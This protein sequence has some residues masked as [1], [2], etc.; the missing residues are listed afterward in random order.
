VSNNYFCTVSFTHSDPNTLITI[1]LINKQSI[2]TQYNFHTFSTSI[3]LSNFP[4]K[5]NTNIILTNHLPHLVTALPLIRTP[6]SPNLHVTCMHG[7]V[8][9]WFNL[10]ALL[11]HLWSQIT[12]YDDLC[13]RHCHKQD[14]PSRL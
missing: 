14:R 13:S 1:T 10:H 8:R 2:I 12:T 5:N 6:A 3:T 4:K 11:C 7:W 9:I